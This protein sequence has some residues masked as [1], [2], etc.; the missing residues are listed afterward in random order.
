[1]IAITK[2][3]TY[4]MY[5]TQCIWNQDSFWHSVHLYSQVPEVR[6]CDQQPHWR[7]STREQRALKPILLLPKPRRPEEFLEIR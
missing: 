5:T 1:M 7:D 3:Y 6:C 2:R 4:F